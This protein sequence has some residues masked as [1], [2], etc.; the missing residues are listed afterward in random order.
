MNENKL[1]KY[2]EK[3]VIPKIQDFVR[4]SYSQWEFDD[5]F[6]Q[7]RTPLRKGDQ[8]KATEIAYIMCDKRLPT[9]VALPEM[10]HDWNTLTLEEIRIG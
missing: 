9:G 5:F 6:E 4:S 1:L 2:W 10:N 7:M 8:T 3:F